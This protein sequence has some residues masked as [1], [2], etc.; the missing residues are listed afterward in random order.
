M[1]DPTDSTLATMA[2]I[3]GTIATVVTML[4]TLYKIF[5]TRPREKSAMHGEYADLVTARNDFWAALRKAY[6]YKRGKWPRSNAFPKT[7]DEF[8]RFA[9][10]PPFVKEHFV[11]WVKANLVNP[12]SKYYET[13]PFHKKLWEL[14]SFAY[15]KD[16]NSLFD[17][18]CMSAG[19]R[20]AFFMGTDGRAINA[21]DSNR[22]KL[23]YFWD[24]WM[25]VLKASYLTKHYDSSEWE[26]YLLVWLELALAYKVG[27]PGKGK[28]ELFKLA[29]K[30]CSKKR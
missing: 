27:Q 8:V 22:A 5:I 1:P 14:A 12:K 20:L 16:V 2:P 17:D 9:G 29:Q 19:D 25:P 23:S 10:P 24:K 6:N 4:L 30:F 7:L 28:I 21:F 15:P 3:I 26:I 11:A 18:P 13:Y